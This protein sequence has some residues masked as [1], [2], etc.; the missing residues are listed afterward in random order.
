VTFTPVNG[1]TIASTITVAFNGGDATDPSTSIS[2]T[3]GEKY[4]VSGNTYT[5]NLKH[6][7]TVLFSNVPEGVTYAVT[8][9]DPGEY[10]QTATADTG[11]INGDITAKFVNELGADIDTGI[12]M[13]SVPYYVMIAIVIA[14]AAVFFMKRRA[15]IEE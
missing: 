6:D 11:T 15:S 3:D 14:A 5:F 1:T 7:E 12:N 8:E 13:D 10:T 2:A 4:T 9:T